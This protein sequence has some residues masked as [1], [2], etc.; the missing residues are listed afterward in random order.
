MSLKLGQSFLKFLENSRCSLKSHYLGNFFFF[1][2]FSTFILGHD[3]C[4][5]HGPG[6][7]LVS[8]IYLSFGFN[9]DGEISLN[10]LFF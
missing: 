7:W 2:C 8:P 3:T 6:H 1:T 4:C 9:V 10:N 5:R